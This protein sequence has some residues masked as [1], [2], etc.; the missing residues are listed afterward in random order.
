MTGTTMRAVGQWTAIAVCGLAA[1]AL[2]VSQAFAP[3]GDDSTAGR[4]E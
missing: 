3:S 4:V 1:A 2:A